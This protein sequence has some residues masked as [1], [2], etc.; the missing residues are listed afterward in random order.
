MFLPACFLFVHHASCI[1][2]YLSSYFYS[3]IFFLVEFL[4]FCFSENNKTKKKDLGWPARP[5]TG[6]TSHLL[7][8]AQTLQHTPARSSPVPR[9]AVRRA[10]SLEPSCPLAP[11]A[12][13]APPRPSLSP[14]RRDPVAPYSLTSCSSFRSPTPPC[15]PQRARSER[16]PS[17]PSPP[18]LATRPR[19]GPPRPCTPRP[20]PSPSTFIRP[21]PFPL[22]AV[23]GRLL[24]WQPPAP[25]PEPPTTTTTPTCGAPNP[26]PPRR[27]R[28]IRAA[29]RRFLAPAPVQRL[30]HQRPILLASARRRSDHR[31]LATL[32]RARSRARS[33]ACSAARAPFL[34]RS[35]ARVC[36]FWPFVAPHT[37]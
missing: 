20:A 33:R 17:T 34:V 7:T 37:L 27:G 9:R 8:L 4:F 3:Q 35:R 36:Y 5:G 12:L 26:L 15:S 13:L 23:D 24:P 32:P 14:C 2:F 29:V 19:S 18:P 21:A 6:P 22:S 30:L 28:A 31:C 10:S 16:R 11:V 1:A 25:S